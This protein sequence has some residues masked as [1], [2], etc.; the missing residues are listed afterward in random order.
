L[1]SDTNIASLAN[2]PFN[3]FTR[4][5]GSAIAGPTGT[6]SASYYITYLGYEAAT[7]LFIDV[8]DGIPA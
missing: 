3:A 4:E 5:L 1:K 2:L 7:P 8:Y 6:Y